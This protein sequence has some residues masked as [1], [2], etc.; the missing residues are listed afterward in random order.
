MAWL[1]VVILSV[2]LIALTAYT[3]KIR[4]AKTTS[5]L[6]ASIQLKILLKHVGAA[7]TA[8]YYIDTLETTEGSGPTLLGY[9]LAAGLPLESS[10][11]TID[12]ITKRG[13]TAKGARYIENY[14]RNAAETRT[15]VINSLA[16]KLKL[17]E[18]KLRDEASD[19]N[20]ALKNASHK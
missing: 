12:I 2:A 4:K 8:E 16:A 3:L 1:I 19:Y 17:M 5:D 6:Y 9:Y 20:E 18:D 7:K 11:D 13:P 10:A 14:R 15:T